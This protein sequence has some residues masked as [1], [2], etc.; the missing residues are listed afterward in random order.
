MF[1]NYE[2]VKMFYVKQEENKMI[3]NVLENIKKEVKEQL[4]A[5]EKGFSINHA[6]ILCEWLKEIFCM[7]VDELFLN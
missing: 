1:I 6:E 3:I 4:W 5:D 7:E 2:R